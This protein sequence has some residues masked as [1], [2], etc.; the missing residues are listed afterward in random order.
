MQIT[1]DL[2]SDLEQDLM[3]QADEAQVPLSEL[4]LQVLRQGIQTQ[5]TVNAQW[6]DLVL[7]Y[8]GM[9][10]FPPFES[11]HEELLPPSEQGAFRLKWRHNLHV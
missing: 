3:W 7:A 5:A 11:Y 1:I 4:V 10:D 6:P 8:E 9:P 2:P